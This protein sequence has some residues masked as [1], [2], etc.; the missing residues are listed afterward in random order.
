MI[1]IVSDMPPQA[2]SQASTPG[3][4]R[5]WASRLLDRREWNPREIDGS[6]VHNDSYVDRRSL[7]ILAPKFA[8][9]SFETGYPRRGQRHVTLG[10]SSQFIGYPDEAFDV[11]MSDYPPSFAVRWM[12]RLMDQPQ[13]Y[14][15]ATQQKTRDGLSI[16]TACVKS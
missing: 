16:P 15:A 11:K 3:H 6:A 5:K 7:I 2:R 14:S 10:R 8:D 9:P 4:T 13:P 1:Q 12:P